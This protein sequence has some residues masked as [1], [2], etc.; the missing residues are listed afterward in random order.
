MAQSLEVNK[1]ALLGIRF[2]GLSSH[3]PGAAGQR[4]DLSLDKVG[5]DELVQPSC[6]RH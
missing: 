2:Q 1:G 4:P 6:L 5:L 3:H